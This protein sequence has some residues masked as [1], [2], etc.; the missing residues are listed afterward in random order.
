MTSEDTHSRTVDLLK[1]LG[2]SEYVDSIHLMKQEKV[3]AIIDNEERFFLE[4]RGLTGKHHGKA[5]ILLFRDGI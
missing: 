5:H 1:T 4:K 3:P 2:H